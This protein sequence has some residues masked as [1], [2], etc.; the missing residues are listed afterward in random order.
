[1][2]NSVTSIGENAFSGCSSLTSVN[3]PNSVDY[4]GVGAFRN[5]SSLT[6][7]NIG[8]SVT[9]IGGYAF[10]G[11]SRLTSVTIPNSVN[12]IGNCAFRECNLG[13]IFVESQI[14]IS[15]ADDTFSYSMRGIYAILY[16]P[17]GCKATYK[18]ATYWKDFKK[19]EEYISRYELVDGQD[20]ANRQEGIYNINYSR[21]FK[22]TNW[23]AWY[24]PFELDL[25]KEVLE[26]FSFAKFAGTYTEEDGN[27][28]ITVAR[29][30]EGEVVKA[31]TPY[32]VQAKVADKTNPQVIMQADATLEAAEE[33][34]FYVLSAEKKITFMGNYTYKI[35]IEADENWYALSGGQYSRQLPGNT[36]APFRCF[37]T[38][39]DRVDNPYPASPNPTTVRLMVLGDEADEIEILRNGENEKMRNEAGA[40]FDLS[41]R[42]MVNG[43]RYALGSSK[44][45]TKGI[46]II[47]GKKV[48]VK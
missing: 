9:S 16:V 18:S 22:N 43:T 45:L 40:V 36:I 37:F 48:L 4:I 3:I 39:E 46:Y 27:F 25:T 17:I 23:Q 1:M 8:N 26:K 34:S 30:K 38:I 14:P 41:G 7:V 42:Q 19:I 28:Y 32:C 13:S 31:N 20:Y 15:I 29:M 35:V 6:S 21:T 44:K 24:V 10:E 11:C 2:G 33:T 5:C 12:K 47:N